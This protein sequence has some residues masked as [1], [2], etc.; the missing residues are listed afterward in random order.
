MEVLGF[1]PDDDHPGG[2]K[3]IKKSPGLTI[4][5]KTPGTIS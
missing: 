1:I 2:V 5:I 4:V 3:H